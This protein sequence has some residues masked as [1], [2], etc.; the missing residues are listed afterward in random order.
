MHGGGG[1]ERAMKVNE[2]DQCNCADNNLKGGVLHNNIG[3]RFS[4]TVGPRSE[5]MKVVG[6]LIGFSLTR[7]R[8][9]ATSLDRCAS[10]SVLLL[11]SSKPPSLSLSHLSLSHLLLRLP[12]KPVPFSYYLEHDSV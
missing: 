7:R 3:K 5:A 9:V 10:R 4:T 11:I 12:L 8:R 6:Q 2:N 1:R